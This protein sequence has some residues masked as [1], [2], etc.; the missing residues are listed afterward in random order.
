MALPY[1]DEWMGDHLAH[2]L[3]D[4]VHPQF[5]CRLISSC[6]IAYGRRPF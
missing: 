4:P 2:C 1:V 5:E 3:L 6:R